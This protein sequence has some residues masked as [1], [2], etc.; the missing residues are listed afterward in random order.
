MMMFLNH[1]RVTRIITGISE[2]RWSSQSKAIYKGLPE[3]N[4]AEVTSGAG[5]YFNPRPLIEAMVEL[6]GCSSVLFLA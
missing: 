5:Q 3:E 1:S 4:A 2:V 6:R